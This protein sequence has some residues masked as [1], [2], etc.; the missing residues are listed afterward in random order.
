MTNTSKIGSETFEFFRFPTED[1][2]GA[3]VELRVTFP[4]IELRATTEDVLVRV[5]SPDIALRLE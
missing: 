3:L 4:D 1:V 5:T 2:K